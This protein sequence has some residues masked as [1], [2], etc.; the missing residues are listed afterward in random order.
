VGE[1]RKGR[2]R[3]NREKKMDVGGKSRIKKREKNNGEK[4][5][6]SKYENG[7]SHIN[8]L[9]WP[10][11]LSSLSSPSIPVVLLRLTLSSHP[12]IYLSFSLLLHL[13]ILLSISF[14]FSISS[15]S[16]IRTRVYLLPQNLQLGIDRSIHRVLGGVGSARATNLR[17]RERERERKIH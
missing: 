9:I 10:P 1:K 3:Q 13:L 2:K 4:E 6:E 14:S 17:E 12:S 8:S 5:M 7:G 11:A 15:F 16:V